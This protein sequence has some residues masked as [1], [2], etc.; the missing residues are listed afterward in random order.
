MSALCQIR[1]KCNAAKKALLDH[2]LSNRC[3]TPRSKLFEIERLRVPLE[4]DFVLKT[5]REIHCG[6]QSCAIQ[7]SRSSP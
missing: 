4:K 6:R 2:S 7:F 5:M 3:D 1:T